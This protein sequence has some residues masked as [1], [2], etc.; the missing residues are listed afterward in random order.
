M[1]LGIDLTAISRPTTGLE[2]VA[3][4]MTKALLRA[5]H[6][7][8]Y[9]LFF[10]RKVHPAFRDVSR[11]FKEV[12]LRS[13]NEVI[14]KSAC[15]PFLSAVRNL[16]FL[17]FPIFPPP[18][19]C[20]C[21]HGWTVPDA[22]PW[23]YPETMKF[24]SRFYFRVLGGMAIRNSRLLITDTQSSKNDLAR[25]FKN[26]AAKLR[27]IAPGLR[28]LFR[29]LRAPDVLEKVRRKYSLPSD[30]LLFVGTIEPRKNLTGLLRS[31]TLLK[32]QTGFHPPLVI[33][34][35]KGW[36]YDSVF[37]ELSASGLAKHVVLTGFV[38][39]Q[40]L[41]ALYNLARAFVYPSLYEG[42]GLPCIEAMAAGCPVVTSNRGALLEVTGDAALHADPE[43]PHMLANSI[44]VVWEDEDE[45]RQL[46]RKGFE[47]AR[48]FSWERYARETLKA[49][50]EA[51][52]DG[53]AIPPVDRDE[54]RHSAHEVLLGSRSSI[55]PA[56]DAS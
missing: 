28:T 37:A 27:V 55:G 12:I 8:E 48:L 11:S 52:C 40:D 14:T 30:F 15:F 20:A 56:K 23:L 5:D 49:F 32:A 24:N 3:I 29:Q 43:D 22:T 46:I 1:A 19:R 35:R 16:D 50:E 4:E 39:D 18:W 51:L 47:R 41:V 38:P 26:H 34:G 42:F 9:V 31:L 45:R 44:R 54:G 13:R 25:L 33:A 53:R 10:S 21:P 36:L 2:T 6:A 7:N 17:H